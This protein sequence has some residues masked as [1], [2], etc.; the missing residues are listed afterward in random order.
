MKNVIRFTAVLLLIGLVA[1]PVSA[2]DI[3]RSAQKAAAP[4]QPPDEYAVGAFND[5]GILTLQSKDGAFKWWTDLRIFQYATGFWGGNKG[6]AFANGVWVD[7]FRLCLN[8]QWNTNWVAQADL[9]FDQNATWQFQDMYIGWTGWKNSLLR[10]GHNKIPWGMQNLTTERYIDLWTRAAYIDIFKGGRRTGITYNRWGD[11]Y[12]FEVGYYGAGA[13]DYVD[14]NNEDSG[15]RMAARISVTPVLTKDAVFHLGLAAHRD[16]PKSG[17]GDTVS[18]KTGYE[19]GGLADSMVSTGKISNVDHTLLPNV[20]LA[21]QVKGFKFLGEYGQYQ[22][23]RYG[24]KP[25]VTTKGYYAE[26]N[27]FPSGYFKPYNAEVGEFG[28]VIPPDKKHGLVELVLRYSDV[29]LNDLSASIKGGEGKITKLGLNYYMDY[30]MRWM[31]E[32][33]HVQTDM[34]SVRKNDS[35]N[36]VAAGFQLCF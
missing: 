3:V 14:P 26:V 30:N 28:K 19:T 11:K 29:N 22:V 24:G 6:D 35:F 13:N 16:T 33:A 31:F 23:T 17:S 20:E 27:W 5:L 1:V 4:T 36:Y 32:A 18:M 8:F 25:N 2:Q 12:E 9:E 15:Q 10:F 7:Q 34:Y 21:V